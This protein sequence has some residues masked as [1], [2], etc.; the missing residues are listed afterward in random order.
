MWLLD[1][2]LISLWLAAWVWAFL[3]WSDSLYKLFLGLIIGFLMYLVIAGQVQVV[4]L[5]PS[6]QYDVY[7]IF[8]SKN[9]TL[10][11]TLLLLF[12]PI[13]GIFFMLNSRLSFQTRPKSI[14]QLLL[15][16]L[17]PIFLIGMI[18]YLAEGSILSG[19]AMWQSVFRFLEGSG[20][21]NIFKTLPWGIF[22]LLAFVIFYKSIFL[23][24]WAFFVW[25]WQEV[26]SSYFKNWDED[27]K[28]KKKLW[29]EEDS[30][31]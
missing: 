6:S 21:Y 20:I 14:S 7:Q 22:L 28:T 16:L 4:N 13:L 30:K 23:L 3:S 26:I 8:L 24:I 2:I 10:I 17:L 29:N 1:I 25:L 31:E 9:A 18:A 5:L 12:V 27:K 19:S 15:W 11:L